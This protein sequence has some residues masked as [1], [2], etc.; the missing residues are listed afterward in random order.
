MRIE[1]PSNLYVTLG[2]RHCF[3][4]FCNVYPMHYFLWTSNNTPELIEYS[5]GYSMPSIDL[6]GFIVKYGV[7]RRFGD[8]RSWSE[9][10]SALMLE[11]SY[12]STEL[13]GKRKDTLQ[14]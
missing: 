6:S 3:D 4:I 10:A 13:L 2:R 8:S 9:E 14:I 1:R 7:R 5:K 12:S 11:K